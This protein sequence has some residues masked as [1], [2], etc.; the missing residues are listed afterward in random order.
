MRLKELGVKLILVLNIV[1]STRSELIVFNSEH[2]VY[3]VSS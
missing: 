1:G 3:V 2:G